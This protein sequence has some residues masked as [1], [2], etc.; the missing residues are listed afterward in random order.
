MSQSPSV[1]IVEDHQLIRLGLRTAL[2]KLDCCRVL[3][4]IGDG[5]GAVREA[6][7]LR[8]EVILMDVGLPG[9]DGIEATWRIKRELPRTRVIMF[10]SH[11]TADSVSA[12]LG[13]GADGYCTK[14]TSADRIA[15]AMYTVM[16]GEV[17]L[18]PDLV[19]MVRGHGMPS[20]QVSKRLLEV[21][22]QILALIQLGLGNREIA[23]RLNI[24]TSKIARIMHAMID[25]F[26]DKATLIDCEQKVQKVCSKE[27]LTAFIESVNEEKVFADKYLIENLIASGGVGAVFKAKH[28]Y[29]DRPVALKL[30]RPEFSADRFAIRNFQREAMS[31]ANLHHPN[32]VGVYDFGI[33]AKDEPYLVMEYIDGPTLASLLDKHVSLPVFRVMNICAQICAGLAEAHS[34]GIVHCDLKPSNVMI[35]GVEPNEAV[36]LVDFGLAQ[37]APREATKNS[38][39]TERMIVSGTPCYMSPEQASGK[40][41]DARS[42]IYALG[43]MLYEALTGVN[44]FDA[45]NAIVTFAKHF[46]DIPPPLAAVG[47]APFSKS[48][49]ECVAK[50]LAKDPNDRPQTIEDVCL[51]L[52]I[53]AVCPAGSGA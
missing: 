26:G 12:A 3:G 14:T 53:R 40:Q 35:L 48:L 20:D 41:A 27:W 44:F 13:A 17:W 38:K 18:D 5:E 33:S 37:M 49:Q 29:M 21:E 46:H 10:T 16:N 6:Q 43:C 36:K 45:E 4:E 32:I 25:R 7:R 34:K 19:E 22:R 31:T 1:L 30:L 28:L 15:L 24:T 52:D 50:M 47:G 2:E 42:D 39:L 11:T 9:I 8:P 23:A 51:L